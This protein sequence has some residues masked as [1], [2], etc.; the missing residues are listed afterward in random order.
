MHVA[1]GYA[2]ADAA[3]NLIR[4]HPGHLREVDVRPRL[5]PGVEVV[6][7]HIEDHRPAEE[8][9]VDLDVS[10]PATAPPHEVPAGIPV[11][12]EEGGEDTPAA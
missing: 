12:H 9:E 8:G 7:R 10:H 6:V 5:D 2:L 1:A 3:K 4:D 11:E